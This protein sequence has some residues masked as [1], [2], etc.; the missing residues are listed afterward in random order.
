[1]KKINRKGFSAFL[2]PE[3]GKEAGGTTNR[4]QEQFGYACDG[5]WNLSR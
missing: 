4:W 2:K 3:L 5:V 1:M